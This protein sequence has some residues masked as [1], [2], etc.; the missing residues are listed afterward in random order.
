LEVGVVLQA[1]GYPAEQI[2]DVLVLMKQKMVETNA[3]KV[4]LTSDDTT[5]LYELLRRSQAA[6]ALERPL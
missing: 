3:G 4:E 6:V 2:E 1:H 5:R